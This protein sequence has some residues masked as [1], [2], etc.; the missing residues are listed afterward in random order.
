MTA[1]T[2]PARAHLFRNLADAE[3]SEAA[4]AELVDLIENS[5]RFPEN[6]PAREAIS[7]ELGR[8]REIAAEMERDC[9]KCRFALIDNGHTFEEYES[10]S[11]AR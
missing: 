11:A 6:S 7:Y 3:R 5:D 8:L 2:A 4:Y 1:R 9:D 10:W